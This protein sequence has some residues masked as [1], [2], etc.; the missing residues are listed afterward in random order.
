MLWNPSIITRFMKFEWP[1]SSRFTK[2]TE[3]REERLFL[4]LVATGQPSF[5]VSLFFPFFSAWR[6]F[7]V[8]P[9][10][11]APVADRWLFLSFFLFLLL[12]P[13][14]FSLLPL[15]LPSFSYI[16]AKVCRLCHIL[17]RKPLP[18]WLY[19]EWSS[20]Y[21]CSPYTNFLWL[22]YQ[23][24][25]HLSS[26]ANFREIVSFF[27]SCSCYRT[28]SSVR[29]SQWIFVEF[30][31]LPTSYRQVTDTYQQDTLAQQWHAS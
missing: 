7:L 8:G 3:S 20:P 9:P 10:R 5:F 29:L 11:A 12:L 6:I 24:R 25:R 14:S 23:R 21:R 16:V 26:S 17:T 1:R 30:Y 15:L 13:A 4:S 22:R 28:T 18:C 31:K 27:W 2:D 19:T